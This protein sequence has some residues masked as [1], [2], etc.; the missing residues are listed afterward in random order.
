MAR[1]KPAE[2]IYNARPD[3]VDFRDRMY[4]PTL[5]EV[6]PRI[7]LDTYRQIGAPILDQ[8]VEGACTGFG[9]ATVANYLLRR[10]KIDRDEIAVSPRMFYQMA[11]RYDEWPGTAYEGSSARGAMKGWHKHGICADTVWPYSPA[12]DDRRL[13]AERAG[14]ALHRPLGAY[15]RVNHKD[16]VAMHSAL[17]EVGIL[18][19]TATIHTGWQQVGRDGVIVPNETKLGGHAFAIVAY[20]QRGFWIQNS[21]GDDWGAGGFGL[22]TYADW[23]DC[24]MD[25]WVARLGAPIEL[26]TAASIAVSHSASARQSAAYAFCDLRP[27]IISLGNDGVLRDSGIYSNSPADAAAIFSHEIPRLTQGWQQKRILLYAHG[28]LVSESTATQRLAD[29]RPALLQANTYPVSFIWHTDFWTT[30]TNI[31]TE[32]VRGRRPEGALSATLDFL[33][34][35]LDDT[36]EVLIGG[37]GAMLWNEMKENAILATKSR[38]GG[39]RLALKQLAALLANDPT[40]ELHIAGHSAGSI[41]HAPIVQLLATNGTIADGPMQGEQGYGLKIATCTLWAP[42]CTIDLFK[43]TYLPAIQ[44]GGIGRFALFTLTDGAE[45]NDHCANIYHKS[46]LYLVANAFEGRSPTPL[47]RTGRPLLGMEKYVSADPDLKRLFESNAADWIRSPNQMPPFSRNHATAEHHGD[48]DDDL[49]TVRAT[50]ARICAAEQSTADFTFHRSES[51]LRNRR[52]QL[53]R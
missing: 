28:G 44:S 12:K 27:H 51:S 50:L 4:T 23:L 2:R 1:S 35:R 40:I 21:W 13:T 39:A 11:R 33:L 10:R 8:G 20:D 49:A 45:Q 19:A 38:R 22:I 41:F 36:L 52:H 32:A 17:A 9:L 6:P 14:D 5:I 3:L 43:Q 25:V 46:L 47:A 34:D 37:V 30:I 18:Y 24:G 26:R 16:L 53:E 48:F 7:D 15:Y 31:L 42:A 29:Y